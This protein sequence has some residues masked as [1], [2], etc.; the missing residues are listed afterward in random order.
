VSTSEGK[1]DKTPAAKQHK[2]T[3]KVEDE[4]HE[5]ESLQT[6]ADTRVAA[7]LGGGGDPPP[8][9]QVANSIQRMPDKDQ[10]QQHFSSV[11]RLYGNT[12]AAEVAGHVGGDMV[13]RH[14]PGAP[15][16]GGTETAE[17]GSDP[18]AGEQAAPQ[19][20]GGEAAIAESGERGGAPAAAGP[21]APVELSMPTL[22]TTFAR[23]AIQRT[24]GRAAGGR[25]IVTGDITVVADR[26]ALYAQYDRLQI[27]G[28]RTNR[29]TGRRWEMGDKLRW[30]TRRGLRTNAF[31]HSG[32]IWIDATQTDPTATVHEM[33]HV[34]TA[35]SFLTTVGRVINE[36][37]TQRFALRVIRASGHAVTG[38]ERTY[39]QE[40]DIVNRLV[41]I[42]G[43]GTLQNAYFNNPSILVQTYEALMGARSFAVLKRTLNDT[44]A[45]YTA[46]QRLLRP[47]SAATRIAAINTLLDWWVSDSDLDII[48]S[49]FMAADAGD[50]ATIRAAVEPR[51]ISLTS[52]GQ[53]F[54]FRAILTHG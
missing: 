15:L 50:R 26:A 47:P 21:G 45:G 40:Q 7:S 53:R 37:T 12:F 51:A 6:Q 29:D 39:V 20:A 30:N 38:S 2:P 17:G 36:G 24:F 10:R 46:A 4:L 41:P 23:D 22:Q 25:R 42:I 34:N 19:P 33:L 1:T 54:R 3:P 16:L 28:R 31:A 8:A 49:I 32:R 48:E 5:V 52:L 35:S 44:A 9:D 11:Q 13:Q 18:E 43:E 27:E 14:P